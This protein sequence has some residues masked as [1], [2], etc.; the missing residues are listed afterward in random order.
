MNDRATKATQS[1]GYRNKN[2][3]NIDWAAANKWQGQIGKESTGN[4]PRFAVFQTHEHGIR[5]LAVLLTTYQ[6]RHNCRTIRQFIQRWAPSNEN[7]TDAYVFQVARA[8][9][10][11]SGDYILDIHEYEDLR[12]LVEAIITHELGGQPYPASV[13]D[14]GLRM[15]GVPKPITSA[16]EAAKTNTGK[17]A[18]TVAAAASAAAT[19]APAMQSLASL[20][21]W[22]GVALVVAVAAVAVAYVLTQRAKRAV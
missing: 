14:E 4:P 13:I 16:G 22:V 20:P 1:R 11:E 8:M 7:N 10:V 2:P 15:A 17:G 19:A 9:K 12:P 18:I 3:G 5:A 6:D 21:Q